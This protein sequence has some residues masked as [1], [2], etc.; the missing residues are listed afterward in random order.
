M[1]L[2]KKKMQSPTNSF[3]VNISLADIGMALFNCLPSFVFMR[4]REWVFGPVICSVCQFSSYLT[5][6]VSVFTLLAITRER[7]KVI[8]TPLA[9]RTKRM[10]MV[11][12]IILIWLTSSLVSLPPALFSE[13]LSVSNK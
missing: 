4:D 1:C 13:H 2:A 7:Y 12:I 6:S 9:P 5:I 8:M 10:S 3:L 11:R